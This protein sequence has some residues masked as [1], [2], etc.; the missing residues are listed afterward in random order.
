MA[1]TNPTGLSVPDQKPP[2]G[3]PIFLDEKKLANWAKE[4]PDANIGETARKLFQ[5]KLTF[6]RTQIKSSQ[7][8]RSAE[9]IREPL[10][11]VSESLNKHY[12]GVRFPLSEKA[13]KIADLNRQL[14]SG[15]ATA[16]K[17]VIVD[18]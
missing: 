18:H 16:Y 1:K 14:H 8:I 15:M 12:L 2:S 7:R 4:L 6:N 13:H 9:R 10:N 17:A 5:T 11:Y 3:N